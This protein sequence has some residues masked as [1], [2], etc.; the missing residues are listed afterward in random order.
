VEIADLLTVAVV[1]NA[2]EK[3]WY[4]ED[5]ENLDKKYIMPGSLVGKSKH[6]FGFFMSDDSEVERLLK[7]SFNVEFSD[8]PQLFLYDTYNMRY[9]S[10]SLTDYGKWGLPG[11]WE[12]MVSSTEWV[13]VY[14][15]I[16]QFLHWVSSFL[17]D[18]IAFRIM[19]AVVVGPISILFLVYHLSKSNRDS[20][21]ST[22]V[23]PEKLK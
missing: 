14:G 6:A 23:E 18:Q 4:L 20:G 12:E 9:Q 8:D 15:V 16:Q 2:S 3:C 10:D 1:R 7:V 19:I 5:M 21:N 22:E 17:D 11:T 13:P